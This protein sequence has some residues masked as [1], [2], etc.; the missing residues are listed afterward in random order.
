[1]V[2]G[3]DTT[4]GNGMGG[5]SVYGETFEDENLSHKFKHSEGGILSMANAGQDTNGSQFFILTAP[6]PH[7]D[8]S[9]VVFGKV[10]EG[11]EVLR[12][13]ENQAVHRDHTP[14]DSVV[15][16]DCGVL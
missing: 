7:L 6:A 15:I 2:Q 3:G 16:K 10:Y 12:K 9:H 8:G 5:E 4:A 1:M 13:I 14:R 11:F